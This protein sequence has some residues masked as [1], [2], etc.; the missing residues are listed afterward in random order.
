MSVS[1]PKFPD[2]CDVVL[3]ILLYIVL[4]LS[5]RRLS[6]LV[7][8]IITRWRPLTDL[9]RILFRFRSRRV[10]LSSEIEKMYHQVWVSPS[11]REFFRFVWRE[12]GSMSASTTYQILVHVFGA[13]SSPTT[14]IYAF[15]RTARDN[16][17]GFSD[18]A[19]KIINN[20]HVDN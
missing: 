10:P 9:I 12:P 18:V 17:S 15:Q 14:C 1:F 11:D 4:F 6:K 3:Y 8:L 16:K 20:F 13:V 2:P 5:T 7:H 19:D